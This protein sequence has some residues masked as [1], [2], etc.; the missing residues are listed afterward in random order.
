MSAFFG[1]IH[2]IRTL[3]ADR[4]GQTVFS[5]PQWEIL[6]FGPGD[7]LKLSAADV[8]RYRGHRPEP[9]LMEVRGLPW[10]V[11]VYRPDIMRCRARSRC[12]LVPNLVSAFRWADYDFDEILPAFIRM[13]PSMTIWPRRSLHGRRLCSVGFEK[14]SIHLD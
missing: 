2:L 5:S 12:G 3:I 8:R 4:V 1:P 6:R 9:P 10:F 14:V 7:S 13:I 11:P